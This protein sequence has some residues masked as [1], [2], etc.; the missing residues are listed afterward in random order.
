MQK[1]VGSNPIIRSHE[2]PLD[3]AFCC[4]DWLGLPRRESRLLG[5]SW[6]P[7]IG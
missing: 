7:S 1:V 5:S 2:A 6:V 4:L 3:G